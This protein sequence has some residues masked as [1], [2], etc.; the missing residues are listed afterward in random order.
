MLRPV[1]LLRVFLF[2]TNLKYIGVYLSLSIYIYIHVCICICICICMYVYI[3]IYIYIAW[4]A[5]TGLPPRGLQE[6]SSVT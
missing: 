6:Y 1:H 2:S 3:Y 4:M 5:A